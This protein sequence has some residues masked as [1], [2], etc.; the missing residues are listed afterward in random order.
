MVRASNRL[1]LAE[2]ERSLHDA[3]CCVRCLVRRPALVAGGGSAENAVAL[4]LADQALHTPGADHYCFRAF[5]DALAVVPSTLAENA[6][7]NPLATVSN[8]QVAYS[9]GQTNAGISVRRGCIADMAEEKVLQPL[10]VTVSA[11]TLAT[12]TVRSILKIDDIVCYKLQ[13][14][15][16]IFIQKVF[17]LNIVLCFQVNTLN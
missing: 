7:L 1:M 15:F 4:H 14:F 6:G 5:S 17:F 12:E 16:S 10:L 2:V 9:T 11:L 13:F 3:L 8:L